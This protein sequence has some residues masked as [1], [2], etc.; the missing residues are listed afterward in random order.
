MVVQVNGLERE[1]DSILIVLVLDLAGHKWAIIEEDQNFILID[2]DGSDLGIFILIDELFFVLL[3]FV[4][5]DGDV[6]VCED[7]AFA[8]VGRAGGFGVEGL[9]QAGFVVDD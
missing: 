4:L 5:V 6:F 8:P 7:E 1:L 2:T 9:L 3:V